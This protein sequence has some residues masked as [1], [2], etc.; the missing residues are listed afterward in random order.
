MKCETSSQCES[1][2]GIAVLT[3]LFGKMLLMDV[4][5]ENVCVETRG[6]VVVSDAISRP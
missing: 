3:E 6:D 5:V 2:V 1:L 4:G